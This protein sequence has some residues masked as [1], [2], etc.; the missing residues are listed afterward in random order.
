[1]T[2]DNMV[3]F[4]K[5]IKK[6]NSNLT[7]EEAAQLAASKIAD[8][9]PKSRMYYKIGAARE[10]GGAKKVD[11]KA[12]LSDKLKSMYEAV[13][14]P[15]EMAAIEEIEVEAG[16]S[17]IEF[18]TTATAVMEDVGKFNITVSRYG[19]TSIEAKIKVDTIDGSADEGDD[20]IGIHDV[21]TFAPGQ[22]ELEIEIE[23]VDDDDWEPD[24]EFF[25]KIALVPGDQNKDIK[26]GKKNI[27]TI[28][29]LND[30]DPGVFGFDKR[31]HFVKESCGDAIIT[32]Y[33]EDGA[34]GDIEIKWR[35]VDKTAVAGKDFIGC[36]ASLHFKS[37]ERTKEIKIP[38]IDDMSASGTEEY[39]E[40]QLYEILGVGAEGA[41]FGDI[42]MTTVTI[43]DDD[44]FQDILD[45]MMA[46]TNA[47]LSELSL[48]QSSWSKQLKDAMSVNGG[49]L[50]KATFSDFAMHFLTFG[51]KIIFASC[52]PP[53][54][55]GGWPCF[56]VSLIYIGIMVLL[57]SDFAKIFGCLVGLKDEVTAFTLVTFGTSQ[58]DLFAS[59]IAAVNDPLAD[60]SIGNVVAANAIGVFLGLGFPWL[61][62]SIYWEVNNPLVGFQVPSGGLSFQVV[63]YTICSVTGLTLIVMRR[64]MDLFGRAE[65]GGVTSMKYVSAGILFGLW[66]LFIILNSLNAYGII[67][68]P[69]ADYLD[70]LAVL[71]SAT[72]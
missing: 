31:G 9:K 6:N 48:Y 44:E 54:K 2:K 46:L 19:N 65:L 30:D 43:A 26:I 38:I 47:N 68:N 71:P 40:V 39:F 41:K 12:R 25:L 18:L 66:V 62:A 27:M 7:D 57:I 8:S 5:E 22:K 55:A 24:E 35:T 14:D 59:K 32:V 1:M 70:A 67:K 50:E 4:M 61:V 52:P 51:L 23:I 21:F 64:K 11:P 16:K 49:D 53:G 56:W 3:E 45:N 13:G 17:V 58:I 37:G 69:F 15:K 72:V 20:Y 34:D 10:M 63:I 60:N 28:C 33:R 29:I 42:A 36:D